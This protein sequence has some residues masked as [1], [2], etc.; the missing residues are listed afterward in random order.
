MSEA[1][2]PNAQ[3]IQY[4]N[5]VSGPKWVS[6]SDLID[7]QIAPI[8]AEAIARAA[9][10]P[11]EHVLDVGCG[12]GQTT[13]A[14]A[15]RVGPSGSVLGVD[16]S[17][18]MLADAERRAAGVAGAPVR[19]VAADAQTHAFEAAAFDLAFSRFGVMFFADPV[20]AFANL[21][22]ALRP[23]GRIVF[24]CWQA[25]DRNPWMQVPA[26]VAAR[27]VTLPGPPDPH[28]PGPF[29]FADAERVAGFLREAGLSRVRVDPI[30]R[31]ITMGGGLAMPE[32]VDFLLQMGPAGA[33]LRE[34]PAAVVDE[35]RGA[36][37]EALAP[38]HGGEGLEMEAA[39]WV[40]EAWREAADR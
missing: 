22:R 18:P 17:R 36:L 6:L 28:A 40:V 13:L 2:A 24:A 26:A 34:S 23:G 27:Y 7:A 30:E 29:A 20:A 19:F 33:A 39:A 32:I 5:E 1:E 31:R 37:A 15:E 35:V 3:Q 10:A 14:L 25:F 9:P 21:A 12:C 8:G 11:G 38:Y 4:W 16:V